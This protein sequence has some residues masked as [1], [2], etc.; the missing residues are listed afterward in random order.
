MNKLHTRTSI[1]ALI[2]LLLMI[3]CT[4][5]GPSPSDP[6][7][8]PETS[9][10]SNEILIG[11]WIAESNVPNELSF[12]LDGTGFFSN[13]SDLNIIAA[14]M[15]KDNGLTLT[16]QNYYSFGEEPLLTTN[17]YTLELLNDNQF[18]MTDKSGTRQ[19]YQRKPAPTKEMITGYWL[20]D[21]GMYGFDSWHFSPQGQGWGYGMIYTANGPQYGYAE[22]DSWQI[23]DDYR[24][25]VNWG[26]V[27]YWKGE[28]ESGMVIETAAGIE[29]I[30]K[31]INFADDNELLFDPAGATETLYFLR[32]ETIAISDDFK[33]ATVK[34][35][36]G[37]DYYDHTPSQ[38]NILEY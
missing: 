15:Y 37:V 33:T 4:S 18:I 5:C 20:H 12:Y 24:I 1:F 30:L 14:Y 13:H 27:H 31:P 23:P 17:T 26:E 10:N 9:L 28:S 16:T 38:I 21:S 35:L 8:S 11:T 7:A 34:Y 32:V 19:S 25:V 36:E 3:T 22:I 29:Q 6:S 2:L